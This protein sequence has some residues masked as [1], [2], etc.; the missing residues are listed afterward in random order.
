[1]GMCACG[2]VSGGWYVCMRVVGSI[3]LLD[4]TNI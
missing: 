1:M 4:R 3:S 2:G